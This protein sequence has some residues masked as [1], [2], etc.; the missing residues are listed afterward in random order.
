MN[1]ESI[2]A[3]TVLILLMLFSITPVW[4]QTDIGSIKIEAGKDRVLQVEFDV[5]KAVSGNPDICRPEMKSGEKILIRALRPGETN[6]HIFGSGTKS[7][8]IRVIV[9]DIDITPK[10][11]ELRRIFSK[12][13]KVKVNVVGQKIFVHGEVFKI[14]DLDRVKA[15]VESYPN[16][17]SDVVL[18]PIYYEVIAQELKTV[19]RNTGVRNIKVTPMR[20]KFVVEGIAQTP[21]DRDRAGGLMQALSPNAVNAIRVETVP[22]QLALIKMNMKIM[23]VDKSALKDY[24]IHWNPGGGMGASGSYSGK[25]Q[26]SPTLTGSITSFVS[27]LFPKMRKIEEDGRGRTVFNQDILVRNGGQG[28]FF[29]GRE[30]PFLVAQ[31]DGIMSTEFKKIGVT[32]QCTPVLVSDNNISTAFKIAAS[33]I[34]GEG[35]GGAPVIATN[36]LDTDVIIPIGQSIALGGAMGQIELKLLSGS[37]PPDIGYSLFQLNKANRNETQR[38]EVI[39]MVTPQVFGSTQEAAQSL[40]NSPEKHMKNQELEYMRKQLKKRQ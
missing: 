18:S 25:S 30:V 37:P 32:L 40:D 6:I 39:I 23:Q 4:G 9:V 1:S 26:E 29:R 17:V 24:G 21:E 11:N 22:E 8:E 38:S 7:K 19:L 3:R 20:D 2:I 14:R 12:I 16:V 33:R 5:K 36:D 34:V 31:K 35:A 13:E 10:A 27:N 28:R 15:I